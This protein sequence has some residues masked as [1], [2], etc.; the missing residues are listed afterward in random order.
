MELLQLLKV[1][2][3][4][5]LVAKDELDQVARDSWCADLWLF[6]TFGICI[7]IFGTIVWHR[8]SR[9]DKRIKKIEV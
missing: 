8:L 6:A 7:T 2:G 1:L 5:S 4:S 9:L 3:Q